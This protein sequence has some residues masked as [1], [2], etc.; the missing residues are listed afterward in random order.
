MVKLATLAWIADNNFLRKTDEKQRAA[1]PTGSA[2][3]S[4]L[5]ETGQKSGPGYC[6]RRSP[7]ILIERELF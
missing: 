6:D 7:V 4:L 5:E 3:E 1:V 2:M